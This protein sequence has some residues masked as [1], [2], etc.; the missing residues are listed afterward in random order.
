MSILHRY[1][2][3]LLLRNFLVCLGIFVSLFVIIDFFDRIDN[4]IAA[5]GTLWTT[6]E[7]FIFKIPQ[8]VTLMMPLAMLV[9]TLFTF[10]MLSK[11]SEITSM[12]ACGLPILY[13]AKPLFISSL[14]LSA[15]VILLNETVVPFTAR[16]VREIY[17]ID[18]Q[19]KDERGTYSQSDFWLRKD[20]RFIAVDTFD[21]R[22]D[23]ML[24]LTILDLNDAFKIERRIDAKEAKFV[25]K[26]LGWAMN[27]V[28]E[29]RFKADQVTLSETL[30]AFPLNIL[31]D[32]KEFYDV[33]TDPA[34]MSFRALR[35][36]T[37]QQA[38]QGVNTARLKTDLYEKLSFPLVTF[39]I[40]LVALP[41]ALKPAR[42]GSL[43]VSFIAGLCIGF[44]YYVVHSY[45]IALGHSELFPP[46]IAAWTAN[47]LLGAVGIVLNIGAEAP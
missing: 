4:I 31:D 32:P 45:S 29:T 37:K 28:K 5:G 41:F 7:Y 35:R 21:S 44:S 20:D 18:I 17:N 26:D 22:T 30:P 9:T 47:V 24:G 1:T 14:V 8:I 33:K 27:Q 3:I 43:A 16:R 11:N 34:T 23:S 42:S 10:G 39:I 2:L 36:H 25:D 6:L 38:S 15:I 40:C 19:R 46:F 13:I 12:R